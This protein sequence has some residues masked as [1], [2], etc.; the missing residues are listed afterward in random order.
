M[1]NK[2]NFDA[3]SFLAARTISPLEQEKLI[4]GNVEAVEGTKKKKD[5]KSETEIEVTIPIGL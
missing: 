3:K 4:G 2:Q 5:K 1:E